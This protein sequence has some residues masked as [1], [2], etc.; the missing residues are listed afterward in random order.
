MTIDYIPTWV[1]DVLDVLDYTQIK[2]K[3]MPSHYCIT[4]IIICNKLITV[5]INQTNYVMG[6]LYTLQPIPTTTTTRSI[7]KSCTNN[8]HFHSWLQTYFYTHLLYVHIPITNS[9]MDDL[10]GC[11]S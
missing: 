3:Y 6:I 2:F 7:L 4:L 1:L 9:N 11:T 8:G 5:I 10:H